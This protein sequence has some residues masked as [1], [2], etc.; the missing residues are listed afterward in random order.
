MRRPNALTIH[1]L[2]RTREF[3]FT[4]TLH[5]DSA[6]ARVT[7]CPMDVATVWS[8]I[9]PWAGPHVVLFDVAMLQ[10]DR[11]DPRLATADA[12][13]DAGADGAD[14]VDAICIAAGQVQ[15]VLDA[16]VHH[17]LS[18]VD[19]PEDLDDEAL[20]GLYLDTHVSEADGALAALPHASIALASHDDCYLQVEA[21]DPAAAE[22]VL[23][24]AFGALAWTLTGHVEADPV[25]DLPASLLREVLGAA[26]SY[27]VLR[28]H[29]SWDGALLTLPFS[30]Q[31]FRFRERH[32]YPIDG[33]LTWSPADGWALAPL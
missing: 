22:A 32:R 18:L 29:A 12:V 2:D 21:R 10:P 6:R 13:R 20:L 4:G 26:G 8:A 25:R 3:P 33:A 16:L 24:R 17:D 5:V 23:Q 30:R 11:I 19:A 15:A 9:A 7:C 28:D 31:P 27:T 1:R 14:V